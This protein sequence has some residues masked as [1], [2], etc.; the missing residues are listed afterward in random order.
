VINLA[1]DAKEDISTVLLTFIIKNEGIHTEE[2]YPYKGVVSICQWKN[3][4]VITIDG[5]RYINPNVELILKKVV[6]NQPVYV[7]FKTCSD[8]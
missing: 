8:F 7:C 3:A 1:R 6:A 4:R 5:F 2:D